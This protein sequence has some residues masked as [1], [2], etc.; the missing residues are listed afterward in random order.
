[1]ALT[2]TQRYRP[3]SH[4]SGTMCLLPGSSLAVQIFASRIVAF[5]Y[6]HIQPEPIFC[7][8]FIALGPLGQFTVLQDLEAGKI[9][10]SGFAKSGFVRYA[11]TSQGVVFEKLV[12]EIGCVIKPSNTRFSVVQAQKIA[13]GDSSSQP[14]LGQRERLF[15]GVDKSQEWPQV[16]RRSLMPEVLPYIYWLSQNVVL[17]K[18]QALQGSSLLNNLQEAIIQHKRAEVITHFKALFTAGFSHQLVPRLEDSD[19]QG[20]D[21]PVVGSQAACPLVLLGE[22]KKCIRS[23]FFQ[24]DQELL[25]I[26]P[27]LP[28]ECASGVFADIITTKGHRLSIEWTKHIVR[29]VQIVAAVDDTLHL[30]FQHEITSFCHDRVRHAAPASL[31]VR[32]N[33]TYLLD[34]FQK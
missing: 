25:R 11:I 28:P 14:L 6:S 3:F 31:K 32:A 27:L 20:Y 29:R 26:L 13:F 33:H 1:M 18:E 8:E 16:V 17:P 4:V 7:L 10:V 24:E 12:G 34:N 2:I 19:Y 23:L 22:C 5:D 9:V 30:S 21:L 15:L